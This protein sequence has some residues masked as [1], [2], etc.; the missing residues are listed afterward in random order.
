MDDKLTIANETS[1]L[2]FEAAHNL[3]YDVEKLLKEA[4]DLAALDSV[5]AQYRAAV[6]AAIEDGASEEKRFR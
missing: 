2:L 5:E 3:D 6:V 1:R 4:L